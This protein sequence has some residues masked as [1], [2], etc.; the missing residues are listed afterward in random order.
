MRIFSKRKNCKL[1]AEN[2]DNNICKNQTSNR[3]RFGQR[4]MYFYIKDKHTMENS[5]FI[6]R[7]DSLVLQKV[8][9]W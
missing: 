6:G 2:G 9:K 4:K 7:K 3:N 1:T 8:L 5:L